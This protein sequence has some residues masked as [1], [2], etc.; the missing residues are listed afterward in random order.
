MDRLGQMQ[1]VAAINAGVAKQPRYEEDV[2]PWAV[3]IPDPQNFDHILVVVPYN[4][5]AD[6]EKLLADW[7]WPEVEDDFTVPSPDRWIMVKSFIEQYDEVVALGTSVVQWPT[8]P[9]NL[10]TWVEDKPG[11][12]GELWVVHLMT[13]RLL[14]QIR[15]MK[16]DERRTVG[17]MLSEVD[18][19]HALWVH[20][21]IWT[22]VAK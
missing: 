4:P 1:K 11:E 13:R 15:D 17:D 6:G 21:T 3:A 20:R 5:G 18:E 16:L 14:E 19:E 2:W 8:L 9:G 10:P 22:D 12:S 7:V